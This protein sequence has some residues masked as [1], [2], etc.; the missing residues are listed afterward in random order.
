M[1]RDV[2]VCAT[3]FFSPDAAK[4]LADSIVT[5]TAQRVMFHAF[6]S[7]TCGRLRLAIEPAP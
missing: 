1:Q 6:R 5:N 7:V 4:G 2:A 3:R